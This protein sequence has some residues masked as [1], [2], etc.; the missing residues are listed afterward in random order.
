[1]Q[2]QLTITGELTPE[3]LSALTSSAN[4]GSV[5]NLDAPAPAAAPATKAE[6]PAKAKASVST[7]DLAANTE[8]LPST[9]AAEAPKAKEVTLEMAREVAAAKS[10]AGKLTELK[11]ILSELGAARVVD[12]KPEQLADFHAKA[13]AL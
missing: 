1:M 12:L 11:A 4:G 7:A 10:Q 9:P 6:K 2:F 13:S 5:V 8:R 3:I